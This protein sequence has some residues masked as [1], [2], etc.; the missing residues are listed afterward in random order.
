[1]TTEELTTRIARAIH[2]KHSNGGKV[3]TY[4]EEFVGHVLDF[5]ADA[6]RLVPEDGMPLT[7]ERVEDMRTVLNARWDH[8]TEWWGPRDRLLALLRA[9]EPAVDPRVLALAKRLLFATAQHFNTG[10]TWEQCPEQHRG[11]YIARA[12]AAYEFMTNSH[13]WPHWYVVGG[14][15]GPVKLKVL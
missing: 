1:M 6:G 12:Q 8:Y 9:T 13:G 2:E 10:M 15:E 3:P 11:A 5:L 7:A 4:F 14:P